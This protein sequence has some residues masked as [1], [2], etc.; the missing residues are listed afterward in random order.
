M[1]APR[2]PSASSSMQNGNRGGFQP[3]TP[4][5]NSNTRPGNAGRPY[6][7]APS[8]NRPPMSSPNNSGSYRGADRPFNPP[9]RSAAPPSRSDGGS[10]WNRTAPSPRESRG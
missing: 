7:A 10:Y 9:S 4:P 5:S 6:A 2:S 8:A 1:Q 3:F